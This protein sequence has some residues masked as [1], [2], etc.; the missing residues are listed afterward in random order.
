MNDIRWTGPR[1]TTKE[2]QLVF[3]TIAAQKRDLAGI[4]AGS[5]MPASRT[6]EVLD[7]LVSAGLVE[8][9]AG[10]RYRVKS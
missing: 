3:S 9:V 7:Q 4:I 6:I 1:T 10:M 2:R 5:R 8:V